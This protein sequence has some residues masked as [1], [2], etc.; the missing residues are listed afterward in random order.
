MNVQLVHRLQWFLATYQKK[1]NDKEHLETL[2]D[3]ELLIFQQMFYKT[4]NK[5]MINPRM[6]IDLVIDEMRDRLDL[7]EYTNL[8]IVDL[9]H[10]RGILEGIPEGVHTI[11][12]K[13]VHAIYGPTL[14]EFPKFPKTLRTLVTGGFSNCPERIVFPDGINNLVLSDINL[15]KIDRLPNCLKELECTDSNTHHFPQLPN[16]LERLKVVRCSI[17]VLPE[18]PKSLR[19]LRLIYNTKL[20]KIPELPEGL[21]ELCIWN[22]VVTDL[23][24]LPKSLKKLECDHLPALNKIPEPPEGL[25]TLNISQCPLF[26]VPKLPKSLR[27]FRCCCNNSKGNYYFSVC[28]NVYQQEWVEYFECK[29]RIQIIDN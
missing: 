24:K 13:C 1:M 12:G 20:G 7:S 5:A 2:A 23:P 25:E 11:Y 17:T 14:K 10:F 21:E 22:G 29:H 28:Y 26:D 6:V 18:L 3:Q 9:R 16:G 27:E 15:E 19:I 4:V 8:K